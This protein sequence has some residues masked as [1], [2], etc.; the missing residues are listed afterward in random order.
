MEEK[1]EGKKEEIKKF[2]K[3]KSFQVWIVIKR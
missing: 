1:K 2:W 3:Q